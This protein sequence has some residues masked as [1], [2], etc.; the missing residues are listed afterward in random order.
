[1]DRA[2]RARDEEGNVIDTTMLPNK[3]QESNN[4]NTATTTTKHQELTSVEG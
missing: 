2:E 1:M 3:H 4:I